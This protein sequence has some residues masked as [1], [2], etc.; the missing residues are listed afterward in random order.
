[1]TNM[2]RTHGNPFRR[3]VVTLAAVAALFA[4]TSAVQAQDV[5]FKGK[6]FRVIVG[7]APGG[8]YDI[9][10]RT[11]ARYLD[12][13]L[14]GKP[15]VIVREHQTLL[16]HAG[17]L[18]GVVVEGCCRVN[19]RLQGIQALTRM[20]QFLG[21]RTKEMKFLTNLPLQKRNFVNLLIL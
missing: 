1:M 3:G 15:R 13:Y 4:G 14:P 10:A 12:K 17:R 19:Q 20:T 2:N 18:R 16:L 21:C 8:G 5:D 6:T 9:Y 11:M 7:Y